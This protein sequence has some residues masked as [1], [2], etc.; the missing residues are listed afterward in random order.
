MEAIWGYGGLKQARGGGGGG[1]GSVTPDC[2]DV[3]IRG[4]FNSV[5]VPEGHP[6]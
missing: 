5:Q 2:D 6:L 3:H 4:A 1:G